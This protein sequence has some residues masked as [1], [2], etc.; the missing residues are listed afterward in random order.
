MAAIMLP[1]PVAQGF[2][3]VPQLIITQGFGSSATPPP[4]VTATTFELVEAP[5]GML[6]K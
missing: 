5:F 3:Q 1:G 2:G 6:P 4:A